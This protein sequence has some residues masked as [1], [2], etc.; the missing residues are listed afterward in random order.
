V[1]ILHL[2]RFG[3]NVSETWPE[4]N[5]DGTYPN[6]DDEDNAY[7]EKPDQIDE[8]VTDAD[9]DDSGEPDD[10][11]DDFCEP[12]AGDYC[13]AFIGTITLFD[14]RLINQWTFGRWKHH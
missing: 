5:E 6:G 4:P 12:V 7:T 3:I 1:A 2:Q 10:D 14:K 11:D 9:V 13:Q 8:M